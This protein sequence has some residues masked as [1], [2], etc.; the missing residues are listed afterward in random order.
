MLLLEPTYEVLFPRRL[1]RFFGED[2]E[3]ATETFLDLEQ[4]LIEPQA[5]NQVTEAYL[6][7]IVPVAEFTK[8]PE[9]RGCHVQDLLRPYQHR[10]VPC[11]VRRLS[12]VAANEK[13]KAGRSIG[14]PG[15]H[16][17]DVLRPGMGSRIRPPR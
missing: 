12:L 9:N 11:Q 13:L 4:D 5:F 6:M 8:Y 14:S 16:I 1:R 7:A 2:F 15:R 3:L 17:A 10:D